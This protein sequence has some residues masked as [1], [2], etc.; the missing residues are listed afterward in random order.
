MQTLHS[1]PEFRDAE[2]RRR[3]KVSP[4]EVESRLPRCHASECH[5][6][7]VGVL[8]RGFFSRGVLGSLSFVHCCGGFVNKASSFSFFFVCFI[9]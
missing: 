7:L 3:V 8:D 4:G 2:I 9:M 6:M 1:L 5:G